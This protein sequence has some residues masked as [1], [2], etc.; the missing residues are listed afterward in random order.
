MHSDCERKKNTWFFI[1]D[2]K[3]SQQAVNKNKSPGGFEK[4]FS[5]KVS[6]PCSDT[7]LTV[8]PVVTLSRRLSILDRE[9]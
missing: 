5:E 9:R 3:C 8:P 4:G 2:L 6:G 1:F 7:V